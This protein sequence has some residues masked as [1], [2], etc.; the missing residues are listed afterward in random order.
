MDTHEGSEPS[1]GVTPA[2]GGD[3]TPTEAT[4]AKEASWFLRNGP[5]LLP[6]FALILF[7]CYRG[8]ALEDFFSLAIVVLGLGAMIFVHELGHFLV[9]KWC[10]VHVETFSIGFG[11]PLPGCCCKWGETT[12]MIA[13]FP[14]GGYVKM[15]GE[16][17]END[18]GDNDPR[19][20][21]NKS[22]WQRMAIISAGVMMNVLMALACFVFVF[23]TKGAERTPAMVDVVD[24]GSPANECELRT[25]QLIHQIEKLRQ[26]PDYPFIWFN[27]LQPAVMAS[28]KGKEL[29]F[30]VS[31]P[32]VPEKDWNHLQIEPRVDDENKRPVVGIAP[33]RQLKLYPKRYMKVRDNPV[34]RNSPADA[35]KPSFAFDDEIVATT[36]PD[37][38]EKLLELPKDP[39]DLDGWRR[40]YFEFGRR[41]KRLAG[42]PM[43]IRVL[44]KKEDTAGPPAP[45][46]IQ[47][48]PAF[49]YTFGMRMRMGPICSIRRNSPAERAKV[50]EPSK[51]ATKEPPQVGIKEKDIL[52]QVE[53]KTPLGKT[54]RFASAPG[55]APVTPGIEEKP[56]DPEKL[57]HELESWSVDRTV[58]AFQSAASLVGLPNIVQARL[59]TL[60]TGPKTLAVTVLRNNPPS[61]PEECSKVELEVAWDDGWH[62]DKVFP[63]NLSSPLSISGIGIAYS[64]ETS[65]DDVYP[66]SPA[67]KQGIQK[68]DVINKIRLYS[69][70]PKPEDEPEADKWIELKPNQWAFMTYLFQTLALHQVT[71]KL[72][73]R[74]AGEIEIEAE[75]DKTWPFVERG[76]FLMPDTRLQKA[77]S[78]VQAVGMGVEETWSFINQVYGNLRSVATGRVSVKNFGG[79]ITISEVA[80]SQASVNYYQFIVFLGI[81]SVNLA[82]INFLPIPV[83]DGGHMVFLIYEKL[84]G[85]PASEKV[86]VAAT[87]VGLALIVCLMLFVTYLDVMRHM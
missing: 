10:D 57:P 43:T 39:T 65:V 25:R 79:F 83:L 3:S 40:D 76:M 61:S 37:H 84:R 48:P 51:S 81:I 87:Y 66:D 70:G 85:R 75:P 72:A 4:A 36:D 7:L 67:A 80:F 63:L 20:Y 15:V 78:F 22:V 73:N 47:V 26:G 71:V 18:E 50:K 24:A 30:Y 12:Y 8:W 56:L 44:R 41:L 33:A 29:N 35:A 64:I 62:F 11:P 52:C 49:H 69:L 2:P 5:Y 53:V 19:S 27:Q 82:V 59:T 31:M 86:R 38:P 77:D 46:D 9:A 6:L 58:H 23:M 42:K 32:N 55:A 28:A 14:L 68:G 74:A 16:G 60:E 34:V 21:K 17:A 13:L 1:H 54:V 45:V